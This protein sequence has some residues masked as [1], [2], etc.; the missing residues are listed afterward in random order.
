MHIRI[1]KKKFQYDEIFRRDYYGTCEKFLNYSFIYFFSR[2]IL[3][4]KHSRRFFFIYLS[5]LFIAASVENKRIVS[6]LLENFDFQLLY[7]DVQLWPFKH[8]Q[9]TVLTWLMYWLNWTSRR[10]KLI[11][12]AQRSRMKKKYI[13]LKLFTYKLLF[14]EYI[15]LIW[16]ILLHIRQYRLYF[17]IEIYNCVYNIIDVFTN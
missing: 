13:F 3:V 4:S 12:L 2:Q 10:K 16:I 17:L 1:W 14:F 8:K 5:T 7:Y 11:T 15:L 6:Q 9:V